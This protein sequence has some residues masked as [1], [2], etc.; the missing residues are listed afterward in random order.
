MIHYR[1]NPLHRHIFVCE[2]VLTLESIKDYIQAK[3]VKICIFRLDVINKITDVLIYPY[4]SGH[5]KNNKF[6]FTSTII[7]DEDNK[8]KT[9]ESKFGPAIICNYNMQT[10]VFS[11]S[12]SN[13][14]FVENHINFLPW[15]K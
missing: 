3:M 2:E 12:C 11:K 9:K 8:S 7:Q 4:R 14:E 13:F 10:E 1:I 15:E 5:K 6:S